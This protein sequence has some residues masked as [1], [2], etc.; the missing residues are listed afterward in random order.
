MPTDCPS[1]TGAG[2]DGALVIWSLFSL[3]MTATSSAPSL[4][5]AARYR[6]EVRQFDGPH[7]FPAGL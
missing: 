6:P 5:L 1:G 2:V 3:L 7:G 4:L